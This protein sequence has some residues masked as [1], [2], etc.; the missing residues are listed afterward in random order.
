M[1]LR[2]TW[3]VAAAVG[4]MV[5][6]SANAQAIISSSRRSVIS[7]SVVRKWKSPLAKGQNPLDRRPR[8]PSVKTI[9]AGE[10]D[11]RP[12]TTV[13]TDVRTVNAKTSYQAGRATSWKYGRGA[14]WTP[15]G[16][17]RVQSVS[18]VNSPTKSGVT[19]ASA[20]SIAK[21]SFVWTTKG[22]RKRR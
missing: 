9:A 1:T 3:F 2:G 7:N 22:D 10:P 20:K 8:V 6:G 21:A 16:Q 15:A 13:S 19:T 12:R 11:A 18:A 4:L 14:V 17:V 5:V